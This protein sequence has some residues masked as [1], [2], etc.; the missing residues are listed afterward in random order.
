MPSKKK[1][2]SKADT[3]KFSSMVVDGID[4]A[5]SRSMLRAVGFNDADF[6]KPQVGIASTWSM[7]TPCNMHI[8]DLADKA[9]E[10]A[11]MLVVG[12]RGRGGFRGLLLGSVSQQIAHHGDCPVVIVRPDLEVD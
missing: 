2:A 11:D 9:A 8:N 6:R 3:R 1:A 7:V 5:P 10:G 12:S 4:R